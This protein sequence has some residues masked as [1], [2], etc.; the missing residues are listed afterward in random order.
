[1]QVKVKKKT[2]TFT[3]L[4]EE[5]NDSVCKQTLI[6]NVVIVIEINKRKYLPFKQ[7]C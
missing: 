1:M 7:H 4:L 5:K 6:I 3:V 2:L